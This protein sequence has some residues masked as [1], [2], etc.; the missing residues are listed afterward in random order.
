MKCHFWYWFPCPCCSVAKSCL[1]LWDPM[2][3]STP[4]FPVLHYLLEFAQ[5]HVHWVSSGNWWWTGKPGVLQCMG[6]QRVRHDLATELNWSLPQE[7]RKTSNKQPKLIPA[8]KDWGQEEKG[9]TEDEMAGW[10]HRLD[11]RESEWTPGVGDGQGG[12]VCCDSW[13]HK[14]SDTTERLN[15]T[16]YLK[17]VK[18]N[19]QNLKLVEGKK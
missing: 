14:E 3:C 19:K 15:W 7:S 2:N 8:G 10:H 13:G 5:V 12:L 1:T 18:K 16:L 17:E 9:T 11:G 4:D 6:S